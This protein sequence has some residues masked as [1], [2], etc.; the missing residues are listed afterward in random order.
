MPREFRYL[1]M[2]NIRRI[3]R[4]PQDAEC[5]MR[6]LLMQVILVCVAHAAQKTWYTNRMRSGDPDMD[7][8]VPGGFRPPFTAGTDG[9]GQDSVDIPG[10]GISALWESI[11]GRGEYFVTPPARPV[12]PADTG[13]CR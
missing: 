3:A 6:L 11:A 9:C 12:F 4:R 5:I 2:T 1:M 13:L 8:T 10:A 7:V